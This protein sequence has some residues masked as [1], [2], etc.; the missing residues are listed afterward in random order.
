M[1]G[2]IKQIQGWAKIKG[3]TDGVMIGNGATLL[4]LSTN[5]LAVRPLPY[6]PQTYSASS[7]AFVSAVTPTDVFIINGSASK[8]IRIHRIN[9]SG[10]TTSGSAIR[11]TINLVRRST[12]NTGGT[13]VAS[14]VALYDSTNA[15]ATAVAQHYTAN[16]TVGT[17]AGIVRSVNTSFQVSGITNSTLFYDLLKFDSQPIV[18]RGVAQGLAVNLNGTTITGGIV[19]V[20]VEWSEV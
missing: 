8:I 6:E 2:I 4:P 18:L 11:C 16:P 3:G 15:A 10:T 20:S 7:S 5:A 14:S 1:F 13:P 9:V 12:A 19:S 17:S